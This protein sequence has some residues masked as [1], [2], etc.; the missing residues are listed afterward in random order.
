MDNYIMSEKAADARIEELEK[1]IGR[2][3]AIQGIAKTVIDGANTAL[4][5]RK[6]MD[7][8]GHGDDISIPVLGIEAK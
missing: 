2:S 1:E 5:A 4:H 8:Y 3:R 7:T 6:Y